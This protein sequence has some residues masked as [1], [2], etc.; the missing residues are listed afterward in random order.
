MISNYFGYIKH[1]FVDIIWSI[2]LSINYLINHFN[3]ERK[4]VFIQNNPS[5]IRIPTVL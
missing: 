1:S 3:K 4:A 2:G 5:K